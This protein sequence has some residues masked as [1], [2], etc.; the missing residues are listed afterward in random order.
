MFKALQNIRKRGIRIGAVNCIML[1]SFAVLCGIVLYSSIH[2][3]AACYDL[4][5]ADE[6]Y[7]N[8][9]MDGHEMQEGSDNLTYQVQHFAQTGDIKYLEAYFEEAES[10]RRERAVEN[11]QAEHEE[12][13]YLRLAKE[14]SDELMQLEY[15]IMKLAVTAWG[16]EGE[17]IPEEVSGYPLTDEEMDLDAES[18]KARA[19]DLA[20]G[21]QYHALK[22]AVD[23]NVRLFVGAVSKRQSEMIELSK[24]NVASFLT[25]QEILVALMILVICAVTFLF[26]TQVTLV[27]KQYVQCIDD[28][29]MLRA[30]GAYELR[31]LA[32]TY[33]RR[34]RK[35]DAQENLL[36]RRAEH[37]FLTGAVNRG[38][39]ERVVSGILRDNSEKGCLL[40]LDID[41]FK[42]IND[43]YGHDI[44]DNVLVSVAETLSDSFRKGDCI[45]RLGGDEF[46]VWLS[47]LTKDKA[48]YVRKRIAEINDRLTHPKEGLPPV[49]VSVGAVFSE[50]TDD[51]KTL[52]KKADKVLYQVKDGGRCGCEIYG[53]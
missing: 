24:K 32:D 8:N 39:F 44:G 6:I 50:E 41:K 14:K 3:R 53:T 35:R 13:E 17:E 12:G 29:S 34:C 46:A 1:V 7:Y 27:L 51:F 45:S 52:Y 43:T 36:R 25:K 10:G 5:E 37:D 21:T 47:G 2:L 19:A 28:N 38:T 23:E 20:Y 4:I 31:F 16:L 26:Y 11:L 18:R 30:R 15:H 40:L 22:D 9:E 42:E 49:T 48:G 33:N